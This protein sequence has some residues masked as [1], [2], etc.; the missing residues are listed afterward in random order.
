MGL[1]M[2]VTDEEDEMTGMFVHHRRMSTDLQVGMILTLI[3]PDLVMKPDEDTVKFNAAA[4]NLVYTTACP[5][6]EM[7]VGGEE[8]VEEEEEEEEGHVEVQEE[9]GEG[10]EDEAEEPAEAVTRS[11]YGRVSKT[12][13]YDTYVTGTRRNKR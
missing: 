7:E 6:A 8:I 9:T 5:F 12:S 1:Y 3:P 13:Y 10:V 4:W 11:R 2:D